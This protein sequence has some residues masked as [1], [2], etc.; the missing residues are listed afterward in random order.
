[1]SY[2]GRVP[3]TRQHSPARGFESLP[4]GISASTVHVV[5]YVIDPTPDPD[6]VPDQAPDGFYS[7]DEEIDDDGGDT[8]D[9]RDG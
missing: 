4:W 7:G 3:A 5:T 6:D 9:G 2:S 8:A 1:M